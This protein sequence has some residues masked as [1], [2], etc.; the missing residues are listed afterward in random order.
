MNLIKKEAS[1]YNF[2]KLIMSND[3]IDKR[4]LDQYLIAQAD[5]RGVTLGHAEIESFDEVDNLFNND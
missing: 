2:K 5:R 4:L 1:N 3:K